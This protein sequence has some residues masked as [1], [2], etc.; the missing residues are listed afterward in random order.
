[1]QKGL[2]HKEQYIWKNKLDFPNYFWP[3]V[4][5]CQVFLPSVIIGANQPPQP[6]KRQKKTGVFGRHQ[7]RLVGGFSPTPLKNMFVKLKEWCWTLPRS[8]VYVYNIWDRRVVYTRNRDPIADL[9]GK[10][11]I[12]HGFNYYG[13]TLLI[14]WLCCILTSMPN[15]GSWVTWLPDGWGQSRLQMMF[16]WNLVGLI[17]DSPKHL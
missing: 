4:R 9:Y 10:S 5:T 2:E 3:E 13:L 14:Q 6:T 17:W 7:Q 15:G 1:M 16:M 11:P 8:E 12:W